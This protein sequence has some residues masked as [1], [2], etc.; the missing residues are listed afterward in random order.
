MKEQEVKEYLKER[1]YSWAK[2]KKW[3]YGQ[4]TGLNKDGTLDY[5]EYDVRRYRQ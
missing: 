1:G 2:F 3:M 5:Y 4:T